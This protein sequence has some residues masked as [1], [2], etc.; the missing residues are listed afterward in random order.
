LGVGCVKEIEANPNG[1]ICE[2]L[3]QFRSYIIL[4]HVFQAWGFVKAAKIEGEDNMVWL[5]MGAYEGREG[6]LAV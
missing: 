2:L 3:F 1:L 6:I 5:I 4:R